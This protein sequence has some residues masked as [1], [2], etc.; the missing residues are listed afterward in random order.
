MFVN[1]KINLQGNQPQTV[2]FLQYRNLQMPSSVNS[3]NGLRIVHRRLI[4]RESQKLTW[5]F[6]YIKAMHGS[7]LA[8]HS[9][10]AN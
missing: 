2:A 9:N 1:R 5:L 8:G 6:S 4:P 7:S 3:I 10:R